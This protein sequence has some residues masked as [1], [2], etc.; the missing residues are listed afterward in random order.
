MTEYHV[1]NGR[2]R[3]SIFHRSVLSRVS[4]TIRKVVRELYQNYYISLSY[5]YATVMHYARVIAH[6]LRGLF[7]VLITTREGPEHTTELG[8]DHAQP[9]ACTLPIFHAPLTV[10]NQPPGGPPGY[11]SN[12]GHHFI[13]KN[14]ALLQPA[15]HV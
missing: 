2:L 15:F 14:P 9:S 11:V 6:L 5:F 8:G 12:D 7:V 3:L 13:C 10:E 1:S 4:G